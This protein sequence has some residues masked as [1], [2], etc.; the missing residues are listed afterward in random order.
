MSYHLRQ[1]AKWKIVEEVESTDG[2]ERRW[3]LHLGG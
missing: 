2:R 3:K 1:L